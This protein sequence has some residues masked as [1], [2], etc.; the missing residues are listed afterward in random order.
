MMMPYRDN[1]QG[2][3]DNR[4][5]NLYEYGFA[6]NAGKTVA[7]VTFPNNRNVVILAATLSST[8]AS[9]K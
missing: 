1:G 9:V 2:Q 7:S 4:T 6:L 5:F 8:S 3:I